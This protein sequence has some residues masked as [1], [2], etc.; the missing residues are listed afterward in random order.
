MASNVGEMLREHG[1]GLASTMKAIVTNA[2]EADDHAKRLNH[3]RTK[4]AFNWPNITVKHYVLYQ[5]EEGKPTVL[6]Y[7][8]QVPGVV[9]ESGTPLVVKRVFIKSTFEAIIKKT[10]QIQ[11]ETEGKAHVKIGFLGIPSVSLDVTQKVAVTHGSE[12]N[13]HNTFDMEMELG[14]G[15]PAFGYIEIV[16]AIVTT[17][18]NTSEFAMRQGLENPQVISEDEAKKLEEDSDTPVLDATPSDAPD[19]EDN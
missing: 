17:I 12:D 13:Q 5:N 19:G 2:V 14:Q 9:I 1:S 4:E 18:R 8:F 11:S 16:K 15:E 10:T 6:R 7:T 3:E